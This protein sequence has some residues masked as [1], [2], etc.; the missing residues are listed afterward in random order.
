MEWTASRLKNLSSGP[1]IKWSW[2]SRASKHAK[3]TKVDIRNMTSR[4]PRMSASRICQVYV[5]TRF[6]NNHSRSFQKMIK[7][8][9]FWYAKA[10]FQASMPAQSKNQIQNPWPRS[11]TNWAF[12][13]HTGPKMIPRNLYKPGQK[14]WK[15]EN[16]GKNKNII[17]IKIWYSSTGKR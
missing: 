7:K 15:Y 16:I 9:H 10:A 2:P 17:F 8:T 11:S 5:R 12:R 1:K 13:R 3:T 14:S 4:G 6:Y